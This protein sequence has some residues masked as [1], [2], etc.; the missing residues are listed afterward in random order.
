MA[1]LFTEC[2]VVILIAASSVWTNSKYK[3]NH[4]H[5]VRLN[6]KKNSLKAFSHVLLLI[7]RALIF[8]TMWN[9]TVSSQKQQTSN[10]KQA[11]TNR[12]KHH[13]WRVIRQQSIHIFSP[14]QKKSYS[15]QKWGIQGLFQEKF[16]RY[17]PL[18]EKNF[19]SPWKYNVQTPFTKNSNRRLPNFWNIWSNPNKCTH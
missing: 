14:K 12:E 10:Y 3:N 17:Q 4:S 8:Q 19:R 13:N 5:P 1:A 15:E 16:L 2:Y 6:R 11:H 9:L 18:L 7:L